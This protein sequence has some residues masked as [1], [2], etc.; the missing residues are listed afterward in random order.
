MSIGL[1]IFC[2]LLFAYT[3][4]ISVRAAAAARLVGGLLNGSVPIAKTYVGEISHP[5]NQGR[6]MAIVMSSWQIGMMVGPVATLTHRH[7]VYFFNSGTL[8]CVL[9]GGA[10]EGSSRSSR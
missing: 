8:V 5:A 2:T 7:S 6:S 10:G 3:T 1:Q 9:G 4:G